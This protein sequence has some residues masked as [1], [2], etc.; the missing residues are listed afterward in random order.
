MGRI[1]RR[2]ER[3]ALSPAEIA[4]RRGGTGTLPGGRHLVWSVASGA[5][6]RRWR[7]VTTH[8]DGRMEASLLVEAAP[9][10]RLLKLELATGEGLLTL[11]PDGH[12]V[13]LHGNVVRAAGV[14][15]IALS[16]SVAHVL[17]AGASPVTAAVAVDGPLARI[18]V[19]E[20][21]NVPAVEVGIDLHPRA[22]TWHVA[23]TAAN[24][25]RLLAA[26]GGR[27]LVLETDASGLPSAADGV[28]WPLE[29]EE[30]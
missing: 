9:D 19:G 20:G 25:W 26:D 24:R 27:S 6:G 11:H 5:R 30:R 1:A 28:S 10:G 12:P 14:E 8:G 23:H 4:V 15:H 21:L 18:G 3:C 29:R 22:A 17:L 7:S 13:R 2:R 16:W